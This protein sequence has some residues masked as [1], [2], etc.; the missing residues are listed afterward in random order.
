M[1]GSLCACWNMLDDKGI[2]W[3]PMR[4][5]GRSRDWSKG[6]CVVIASPPERLPSNPSVGQR[7]G[8]MHDRSSPWT[9]PTV[10]HLPRKRV[11]L[12][13][14]SSQLKGLFGNET[15]PSCHAII[16]TWNPQRRHLVMSV[17]S[18]SSLCGRTG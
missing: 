8:A 2:R 16:A 4:Y 6:L 15:A 7:I 12:V 5:T 18:G 1:N 13:G 3:Y 10:D 14:Y 17:G 9:V 11:V